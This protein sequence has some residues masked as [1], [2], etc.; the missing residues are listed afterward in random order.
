MK[1]KARLALVPIVL[2]AAG[3]VWAQD[4]LLRPARVAPD[5]MSGVGLTPG[6]PPVPDEL[7]VS[8]ELNAKRSFPF[9]GEE[10]SVVIFEST[11]AKTDHTESPFP[12]DEFI[13]VLSGKLILTDADGEV[14]EYTVGDSVVV[15]KG[16]RG[17]WE[18][19][20]NYRE[21]VVVIAAE[22]SN[23]SE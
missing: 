10:L 8:G 12:F 4:D 9:S 14:E 3:S 1:E 16:W 20:G 19:Q 23:T 11:P 15:P 21:L 13:Y 5:E 18:M 22:D 7:V 2:L 6:A 17:Y